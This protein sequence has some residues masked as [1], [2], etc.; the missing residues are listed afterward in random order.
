M[1]LFEQLNQTLELDNLSFEAFTHACKMLSHR[2]EFAF[3]AERDQRVKT[4]PL[5]L[6]LNGDIFIFEPN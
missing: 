1:E 3:R 4:P 5:V 2:C 6:N